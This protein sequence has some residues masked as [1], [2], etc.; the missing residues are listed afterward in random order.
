MYRELAIVESAFAN[1]PAFAGV[2]IHHLGSYLQL[3]S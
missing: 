3:G 1:E 2:A